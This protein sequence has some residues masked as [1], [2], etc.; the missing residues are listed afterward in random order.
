M[1]KGEKGNARVRSMIFLKFS[2]FEK[3]RNFKKISN[4]FEISSFFKRNVKCVWDDEALY[5]SSVRKL[6]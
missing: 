6:G 5:E 4:N 3:M 1:A 2:N